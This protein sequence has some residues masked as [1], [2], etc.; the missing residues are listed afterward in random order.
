[1]TC[2]K[3][4]P[5]KLWIVDN[6]DCLTKW[7][8]SFKIIAKSN[9]L[10]VIVKLLLFVIAACYLFAALLHAMRSCHR[11][12]FSNILP[13]SDNVLNSFKANTIIAVD[14]MLGYLI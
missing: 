1:M 13:C 12:Y 11:E 14:L 10:Q 7:F 4:N 5:S 8:T 9:L 3:D 6:I 2:F